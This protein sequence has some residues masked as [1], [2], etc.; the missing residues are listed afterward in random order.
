MA[1]TALAHKSEASVPA[2]RRPGPL[3]RAERR[4]FYLF[5][6]PW[7]IGFIVFSAGPILAAGYFSFTN[8]TDLDLHHL[9]QFVGLDQYN[10][11][12]S[13]RFFWLSLRVTAIYTGLSVPINIVAAL[14]IAIL[15]NQKIP[16]LRAF[17]TIYYMPTVVAGVAS[18]LLWSQ[19]LRKDDGLL[20]WMLSL[21][22]LGPIDWI[23]D[24]GWAMVTLLLYNAWYLESGMVIFLAALQAVPSALYEAA[25]IDG[26][27]AVSRFWHI[28]LPQISPV[29]LFNAVIGLIN[30]LQI[31]IPPLVIT[32]KGGPAFA[33]YVYGLNLFD[34]AFTDTQAG[35]GGYTSA[36]SWVLFM[37]ALVL[38][39]VFFQVS[40]DIVYYESGTA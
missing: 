17:R 30:S 28:S 36:M 22:R 34:R 3:A 11:L 38:T 1:S 4:A 27:S 12:L 25:Q 13:D 32:G 26:A 10:Q 9:P 5:I 6:G 2:R 35:H 29:I 37:V 16:G 7:I 15:L 39:A 19:L 14:A 18:A 40:K 24:G 23:G 20:N 21:A 8:L 33:T 31:F